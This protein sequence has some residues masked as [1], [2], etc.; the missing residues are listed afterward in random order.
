MCLLY[1]CMIPFAKTELYPRREEVH[2]WVVFMATTHVYKHVMYL[3]QY[4]SDT[5]LLLLERNEIQL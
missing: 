4:T 2:P 1:E 3:E 5:N